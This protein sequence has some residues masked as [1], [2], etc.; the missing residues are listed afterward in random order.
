MLGRSRHDSSESVLQEENAVLRRALDE[1]DVLEEIAAAT[2]TDRPLDSIIELIVEKCTACL[3]AEQGSVH[4]LEDNAGEGQP[5][6]TL[7]RHVETNAQS[8]PYRLADQ[9]AGWML[10]HREPLTI[11]DPAADKRVRV[12]SFAAET[13][14]SLLSVPLP[15]PFAGHAGSDLDCIRVG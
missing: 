2:V 13:L 4:L 5:I 6:R 12:P 10:S 15:L 3:E 9:L 11:N 7:L 14:K 8:T 1:L